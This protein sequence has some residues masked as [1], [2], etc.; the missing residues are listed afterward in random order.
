MLQEIIIQKNVVNFTCVSA[1]R[2]SPRVR[3]NFWN[4]ELSIAF[5]AHSVSGNIGT[6]D[7][8]SPISSITS[9]NEDVIQSI[10]S[11]SP[12]REDVRKKFHA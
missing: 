1:G 6:S 2:F 3:S 5:C 8:S 11:F 10:A 4:I 7:S 9:S 12:K